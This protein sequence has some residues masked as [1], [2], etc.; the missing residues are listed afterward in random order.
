MRDV[1]GVVYQHIIPHH[2][3]INVLYYCRVLRTLKR[4]VN[5]RKPDLKNNWLL[6]HDNAKPHITSIGREFSEKEKNFLP[7]FH[8]TMTAKWKE[9]MLV[10]IVNDSG[11]F[12]KDIV[13][14]DDDDKLFFYL[15][16]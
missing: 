4:R 11:Y 9:R 8:K 15:E 7:E 12:E 16:N 13:D 14:C 3:T 1:R 5:R 2:M 10:C 6:H